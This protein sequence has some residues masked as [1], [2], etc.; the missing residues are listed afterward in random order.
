VFI[1]SP[2]RWVA[3]KKTFKQAG[4]YLVR[5]MDAEKKELH[6]EELDVVY[7]TKLVFCTKISEEGS[8]ID[9]RQAFELPQESP[10]SLYLFLKDTAPF[11]TS[12]L[13][14]EVY[15]HGGDSYS[16]L[17]STQEYGVDLNWTYTFFRQEIREAGDYKVRI[18]NA[19]GEP[20]EEGYF[21]VGAP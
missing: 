15:R 21:Y 14:V 5:I 12:S 18:L 10:L 11:G 9:H 8:P 4:R 16:E 6:R 7:K 1:N 20:V 17:I 3:L 19:L 2:K 13:R